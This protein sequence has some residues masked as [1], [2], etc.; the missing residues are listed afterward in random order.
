MRLHRWSLSMGL[1]VVLALT[2]CGRQEPSG[3]APEKAPAPATAPAVKS[4][5]P[6]EPGKTVADSGKPQTMTRLNEDGSGTRWQGNFDNCL[7]LKSGD[8]A[9]SEIKGRIIIL[10]LQYSILVAGSSAILARRIYCDF[11]KM[12]AMTQTIRTAV[13]RWLRRRA[14]IQV[15]TWRPRMGDQ[16]AFA[17]GRILAGG[18]VPVP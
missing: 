2:A 7:T 3:L 1:G 5:A 4:T 8:S 16:Q 14:S 15:T 11:D 13:A 10:L 12:K 6:A 17:G 18:A 9:A